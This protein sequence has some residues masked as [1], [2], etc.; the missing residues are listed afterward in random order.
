M[1]DLKPCPLCGGEAKNFPAPGVASRCVACVGDRSCLWYRVAHN[2]D[3]WQSLPRPSDAVRE[4]AREMREYAE[5]NDLGGLLPYWISRLESLATPESKWRCM[6]CQTEQTDK[7][8]QFVM[9][10][11]CVKG[12]KPEPVR[13]V[14]VGVQCPPDMPF[15]VCAEM[16]PP[17][18]TQKNDSGALISFALR[19]NDT[20]WRRVPVHGTPKQ[21]GAPIIHYRPDQWLRFCAENTPC[22]ECGEMPD[23]DNSVN[24]AIGCVNDLCHAQG[25][26]HTPSEWLDRNGKD[27]SPKYIEERHEALKAMM[28]EDSLLGTPCEALKWEALCVFAAEISASLD[29]LEQLHDGRGE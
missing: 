27:G 9:C 10:N 28:G 22:G 8:L 4:I 20:E 1:T 6:E 15:A 12:M 7:D 5:D 21:P 26:T 29:R 3:A 14:W 11:D 24:N 18:D 16:E 2:P 25:A 17:K 13:E 23:V 19:G